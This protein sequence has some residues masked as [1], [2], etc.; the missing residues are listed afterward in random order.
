MKHIFL[1]HTVPT[2]YR[3][4]EPRLRKALGEEVRVSNLLDTYFA[5][6]MDHVN[7]RN[8]LFLTLKSAELSGADVIA[9]I[10]STLTPYV[11]EVAPFIPTPVL[12]I[13]AR[14]GEVAVR[15]GKR[16]T[17]IASA[18]SP[19]APTCS[20]IFEAAAKSG[21]DVD[22]GS[23]YDIR[24]FNAMMKGDMETHD[25]VILE[26]ARKITDRDVIVFAQGSV[27]HM[28]PTVTEVTGLPVVTAPALCIEDI[29]GALGGIN[30]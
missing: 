24:A 6:N 28:A 1:V 11:R 18:P 7:N 30:A 16:I 4:F 17:V 23:V 29:R 27:E 13:D 8:R 15:Q 5:N 21:V 2:M 12:P 25:A 14:L 9:V 20:L 10:C 19:V 22:V 26:M 3:T